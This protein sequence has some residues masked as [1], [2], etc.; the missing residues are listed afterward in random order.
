M[1]IISL[2]YYV[3]TYLYFLK[4]INIYQS[5]TC[6]YI[7]IYMCAHIQIQI[8]NIA[9]HRYKIKWPNMM[10]VLWPTATKKGTDV[11][12]YSK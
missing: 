1:Y 12:H 7:C 11:A 9:V 3:Y 5:Y 2:H 6:C 4:Y 10:I 8:N